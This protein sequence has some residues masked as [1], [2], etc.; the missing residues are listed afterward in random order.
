MRTHSILLVILFGLM[1]Y[2][3]SCSINTKVPTK[4]TLEYQQVPNTDYIDV[5]IKLTY[6]DGP[7]LKGLG[8]APVDI[9]INYTY[10]GQEKTDELQYVTD[11]KGE[12]NFRYL[13]KGDNVKITAE[14]KGTSSFMPSSSNSEAKRSSKNVINAP[15]IDKDICLPL[16]LILGLFAAASMAA[17]KNPFAIV[18]ISAPRT[19]TKIS[20]VNKTLYFRAGDILRGGFGLLAG[21]SLFGLQKVEPKKGANKNQNKNVKKVLRKGGPGGPLAPKKESK[22]QAKG[23]DIKMAK[24]EERNKGKVEVKPRWVWREFLGISTR[25]IYNFAR[26]ASLN[27]SR[28]DSVRIRKGKKG[29]VKKV[30][31]LS[32]V[33]LDEKTGDLYLEG[34]DHTS[35]LMQNIEL[36]KTVEK[37]WELKKKGKLKKLFE[38]R[39]KY[40]ETRS[41]FV[42]ALVD[43][44]YDRESAEEMA[45]HVLMYRNDKGT[46]EMLKKE[47][48]GSVLESYIKSA[49]EYYNEFNN[50]IGKVA[51]VD[52]KV[53]TVGENIGY[54]REKLDEKGVFPSPHTQVDKKDFESNEGLLRDL[55]GIVEDA[56]STWK[57][58]IFP[59][60]WDSSKEGSGKEQYI[61]Y[62]YNE[63]VDRAL[64]TNNFG[65]Y[66]F[67]IKYE[68][69]IK[70]LAKEDK[71]ITYEN[72]QKKHEELVMGTPGKEYVIENPGR[73]GE[74]GKIHNA[75]RMLIQHLDKMVGIVQQDKSN[76]KKEFQFEFQKVK[77][78]EQRINEPRFR[79]DEAIRDRY[80]KETQRKFQESEEETKKKKK[81]RRQNKKIKRG[82]VKTR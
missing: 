3:S 46:Q 82:K 17:G 14:Y 44:G 24:M 63:L 30:N 16:F 41:K 68:K 32:K 75:G 79:T 1:L 61:D 81:K 2:S 74:L 58:M 33:A 42:D 70:E 31:D 29:E 40:H 26:K 66:R 51:G 53:G 48:L 72:V 15:L 13:L 4:L 34:E 37:V 5:S 69:E 12:I 60:A 36:S 25:T 11:A 38:L 65:Q 20:R 28:G 47:G 27:L 71:P 21:L 49:D 52:A 7:N 55:N 77:E 80:K 73:V 23:G 9:K 39:E 6:N 10:N 19:P 76:A 35:A 43:K 62:K 56:N 45:D 59:L 18:D 50:T 64:N 78:L 22:A 57:K 54:I 8:G 67:L